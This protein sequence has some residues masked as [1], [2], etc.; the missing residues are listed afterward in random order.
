LFGVWRAWGNRTA[1][2]P[3]NTDPKDDF[4]PVRRMFNWIRN[5]FT[6]TFWQKVDA[7]MTQRLVRA[8]VNTF[9]VRLN[10]LRA[11]EAILGG[12]IEFNQSENTTIQLMDGQMTFHIF[13]TP[14]SPAEKIEGVFEYDPDYLDTLFAAIK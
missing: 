5:E 11:I 8:I 14:P 3:A 6:L 12:R 10:G 1:V 13:F 9:N 7:P 2:Y 4:I